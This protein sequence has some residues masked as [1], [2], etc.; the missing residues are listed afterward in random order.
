MVALGDHQPRINGM[1]YLA[2]F[3]QPRGA[4][5]AAESAALKPPPPVAAVDPTPTG[6]IRPPA[7]RAAPANAPAEIVTADRARAWV[8]IDG[9]IRA[10]APGDALPGLGRI[11]AIV[12]RD[13]RWILLD[14]AGK[15]LAAGAKGQGNATAAFSRPLIFDPSAR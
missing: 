7:P 15:E 11:D 2:I 1:Q 9:T 3:A 5:R 12:E 8:K 13:G 4:G 6:S 10:A 14:D